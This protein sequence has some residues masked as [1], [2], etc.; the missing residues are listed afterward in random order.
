[1]THPFAPDAAYVEWLAKR[2]DAALASVEGVWRQG[3]PVE[4]RDRGPLFHTA[5]HVA[6]CARTTMPEDAEMAHYSLTEGA[7]FDPNLIVT[8]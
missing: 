4:V 8:V 6:Y 7:D 3:T 5:R 1:M 2:A